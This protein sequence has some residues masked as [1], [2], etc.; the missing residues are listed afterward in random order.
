MI[1]AFQLLANISTARKGCKQYPLREI[2]IYNFY[3][4]TS[5]LV[6]VK[7]LFVMYLIVTA[8]GTI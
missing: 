1:L 7:L 4:Q 3:P 2:S 8:A 6:V 5:T